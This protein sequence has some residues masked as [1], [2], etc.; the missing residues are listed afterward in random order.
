MTII[1]LGWGSLIFDKTRNKESRFYIEGKWQR[2]GPVLPI[3]F[4][5]KSKSTINP[6]IK[7]RLTLVIYNESAHIPVCWA[8]MKEQNMAKALDILREREGRGEIGSIEMKRGPLTKDSI[9]QT[10]YEWGQNI[11]PA[12]ERIDGIIWTAIR[13]NIKTPLEN[14]VIDFLDGLTDKTEAEDYVRRTP[15]DIRT[16]IRDML[17]KRYNWYP[18]SDPPNDQI[19]T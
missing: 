10:I 4:A 5:R 6:A 7:N 1:V 2:G 11:Q 18:A 17:E 9:E 14:N 8:V 15:K 19:T 13:S 3:E 12:V 16:P